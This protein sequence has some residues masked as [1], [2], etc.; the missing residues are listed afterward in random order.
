MPRLHSFTTAMAG[1]CFA[2]APLAWSQ[3]VPPAAPAPVAPAVSERLGRT[4]PRGTVVGF[5]SAVEKEDYARAARYMDTTLTGE[6]LEELANHLAYLIN[7]GGLG[8]VSDSAEGSDQDG[9]PEDT[10]RIATV[11]VPDAPLN[12]EVVR[13]VRD[14]RPV[15]IFSAE[16][17]RGVPAAYE[18]T[19]AV[20]VN[21]NLP[22]FLTRA[23]WLS[24]PLWKYLALLAGFGAAYLLAMALRP[25]MRHFLRD[26]AREQPAPDRHRQVN[27]VTRPVGLLLWL[28]L[29]EVIVGMAD[30]PY[31]AR[32]GWYSIVSKIGVAVIAWVVMAIV[33]AGAATYRWRIETQGHPQLTALVRLGE[34]T[35]QVLC[36][37]FA[38]LIVLKLAGFDISTMLA[39]LGVGGLAVA[40]A[41][42]RSLEN[43]FGGISVILDEAIRVGDEC[44]IGDRTGK[45]VDIGMRSTRFRTDER[46]IMTVPNGQLAGMTLDN[47]TMRDMIAFRHV[48]GVRMDGSNGRLEALLQALGDL[49]AN[50]PRVD[51][52][53][54]RARLTRLDAQSMDILLTGYIRCQ[55]VTVFLEIQ[56]DILLKSLRLLDAHGAV[57]AAP[58]RTVAIASSSDPVHT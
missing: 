15:W 19:S 20:P 44:Q 27:R 37:F 46:T 39:G 28:I 56:E 4:T 41:A 52:F 8:R 57:L 36:A 40:F 6:A 24:V 47:I 10:E 34:R 30:L 49:L 43:L 2:L 51:P 26:W 21:K 48:L 53:R 50:D 35:I 58:Q 11:A 29:T 55:D 33:Q 42:Q 17:L 23:M 14:D 13:A 9:V 5:I 1:I 32:Q 22:G 54:R 12:L 31:L 3:A 25:L 18:Y 7:H 16:T 45:V 38:L